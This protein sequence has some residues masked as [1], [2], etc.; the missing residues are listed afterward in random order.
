M[1]ALE[2]RYGIR[3]LRVVSVTR[4][5]DRQR[6]AAVAKGERMTYACYLDTDG[7]WSKAAEART[8]PQFLLV[9]RNGRLAF[10]HTG[11]LVEGSSGFVQ[12]AEVLE[13]ALGP[14]AG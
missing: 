8:I 4:E 13:R 2:R 14:S 5:E 3:G 10:R 11:K 12:L 9:D 6:V 1:L 7:A